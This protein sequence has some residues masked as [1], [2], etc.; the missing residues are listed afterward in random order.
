MFCS[1]TFY[2]NYNAINKIKCTYISKCM[3]AVVYLSA[4]W[5]MISGNLEFSQ[6]FFSDGQS[7]RSEIRR[8]TIGSSMVCAKLRNYA[9]F[10]VEV[11]FNVQV[12]QLQKTKCFT[13][14][15][16]YYC[17]DRRLCHAH[18]M[19]IVSFSLKELEYVIWR[20]IRNLQFFCEI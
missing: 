17:F 11:P 1:T 10:R 18:Y 16:C 14:S 5:L 19:C 7:A 2:Q 13:I 12:C 6:I 20:E 9:P 4:C 15:S 3:S 8:A